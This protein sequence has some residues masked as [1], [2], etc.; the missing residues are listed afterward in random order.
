M[1][2]RRS[3]R[4]GGPSA[5]HAFVAP[6]DPRSGLAGASVQ[7]GLQQSPLLAVT[8]ASLRVAI[9]AMKGCRKPRQDT[10]HDAAE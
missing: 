9:C 5:Q 6:S 1:F 7:G 4:S 3:S 8:T 2:G 10:I